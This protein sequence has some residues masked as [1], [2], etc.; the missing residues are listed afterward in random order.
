M[1]Q[2]NK[3][4]AARKR[5]AIRQELRS[6]CVKSTHRGS[7]G[8]YC[9]YSCDLLKGDNDCQ[10]NLVGTMQ[11]KLARAKQVVLELPKGKP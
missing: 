6:Y 4:F 9:C 8:D 1:K 11:L 2:E 5:E 10:G 3:S 7:V